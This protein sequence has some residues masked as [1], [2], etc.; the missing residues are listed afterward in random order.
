MS[1][2]ESTSALSNKT[3]W[4]T[5][6]S[7]GIGRAIAHALADAGAHVVLGAR[8]REQ[9]EQLAEIIASRGGK[10]S[11]VELDVESWP[12]CQGFAEQ[13][14]GVA[15]SPDILINNA[16][17]GI[18]RP[19][20]QFHEDEFEK[21]FRVNVFGTYYMTKLAVPLMRE[22]GGG[23]IVN[24]SSLAGENQAKMGSGYFASKHA[25]HGFTKSLMLDV[26]E[27]N[28]RTTL[29]CPG[30]VDTHF[31]FEA[32]PGSHEKDQSWMVPAEE[33][34]LAVLHA[35]TAPESTM[36]SKIDVRPTKTGTR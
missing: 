4:L 25:V 12:S 2:R 18:F 8:N 10:A 26:R 7:R 5:G 27:H 19:V 24:V 35:V 3:A 34:A 11:V 16:G 31:H 1:P 33:I 14:R 30:S 29:V 9:L 36:I 22:L 13:A 32:H 20:D 6:A 15:G 21:Q 23:I 17:M 28:I